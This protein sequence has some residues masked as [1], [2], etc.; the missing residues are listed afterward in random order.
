LRFDHSLIQDTWHARRA[1]D[2]VKVASSVVD[3]STEGFEVGTEAQ[4]P[5]AVIVSRWTENRET[6]AQERHDCTGALLGACSALSV[7]QRDN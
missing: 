5:A 1:I 4:S 7:L 6:Y 2:D 3:C